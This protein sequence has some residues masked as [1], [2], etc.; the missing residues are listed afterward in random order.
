MSMFAAALAT[1]VK[2][3]TNLDVCQQNCGTC[4]QGNCMHLSRKMKLWYFQEKDGTG[5]H[6]AK[7]NKP[8]VERQSPIFSHMQNIAL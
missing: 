2:N 6:H 1:A 5:N 4:T 7:Q 3:G 8:D